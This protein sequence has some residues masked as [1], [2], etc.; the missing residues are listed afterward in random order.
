MHAQ[1]V[2]RMPNATLTIRIDPGL[3]KLLKKAAKADDR[4]ITSYVV[5][6]LRAAIEESA[7]ATRD[8]RLN[9]QRE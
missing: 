8:G 2:L 4:S 5:R 1:Y 9:G 7:I 6:V 3:K